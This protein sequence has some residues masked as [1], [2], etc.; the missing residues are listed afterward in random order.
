MDAG[1]RRDLGSRRR[2]E[3]PRIRAGAVISDVNLGHDATRVGVFHYARP[4]RSPA[5]PEASSSWPTT[6]P[7]PVPDF[8]SPLDETS[9]GVGSL[10][11]QT[12]EETTVIPSE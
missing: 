10:S 3:G 5:G 9:T 8:R 12:Q 7:R 4:T 1:L 2:A 6:A 11:R